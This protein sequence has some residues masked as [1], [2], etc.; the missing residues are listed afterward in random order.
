VLGGFSFGSSM[1]LRVGVRDARV[2]ALFALG[3]PLSLQPDTPGLESC[4]TPRLFVQGERDVF[5][6]GAQVRQ[7]VEPLPEPRVLKVIPGADHLFTGQLDALQ[8]AVSTW[9]ATRP[10]EVYSRHV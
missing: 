9:A 6:S 1:A 10:W 2:R 3:V 8:D 7:L 4:R 5:G